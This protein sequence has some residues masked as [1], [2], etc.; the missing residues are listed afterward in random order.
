MRFMIM[1][2]ASE[3]SEAGVMPEESMLAEMVAY[4]EELAKSGVLLDASGLHPTSK[5]WRVRYSGDRRTVV[6]GPFTESKELVALME[7]QASRLRARV[8]AAGEPVL[9]LDHD[10]G[11]WD[12][13]LIRR[14]LAALE[15]AQRLGGALGPYALQAAIAACHARAGTAEDTDWPRIVALYDALARM[16]PSPVVE[17]NRAVAVAMAFGPEA[18]LELVDGLTDEPALRRYHLL[19][20]VRGDFL[21]KLDR[22]DE[23]RAEFERAASLTENARERT[24]LLARAAACRRNGNDNKEGD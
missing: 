12:R 23:A 15:R 6:D 10:R 14:G 24:L 22:L 7:I 3:A 20:G 16:S 2:K 13:L 1:V 4:H 19:P 11:R 17:L 18:G 5:A 8:D 21:Y 9:L